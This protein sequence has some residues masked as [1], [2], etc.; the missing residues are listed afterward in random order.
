MEASTL[1]SDFPQAPIQDRKTTSRPLPDSG[2]VDLLL[3]SPSSFLAQLDDETRRVAVA[4]AMLLTIIGGA[5]A[6]G[7]SVGIYRG[8]AQTLVTA[9]KL[10]LVELV[11]AIL[12]APA[13]TALNGGMHGKSDLRRDFALL[14]SAFALATLVLAGLAPVMLLARCYG[15]EYHR[16]I[17]VL[18]GCCALGGIAGSSLLVR[19]LPG[20]GPRQGFVGLVL[21]LMVIVVG[22]QVSWTFRPYI[23]RP[24]QSS[25]PLFRSVESN[26]LDASTTAAR[27][28]DGIY[29]ST[30]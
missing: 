12:C 13:L 2:V 16:A 28:A 29:R 17:M 22:T 6:F 19:G 20:S 30:P 27:S 23:G 15:V 24:S 9:L 25:V 18:I 11:T 26:F 14:L 4:R 1:A 8:G 5:A 3:R 10:P 7:A 21:L